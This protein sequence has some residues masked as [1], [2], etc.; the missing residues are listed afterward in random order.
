MSSQSDGRTFEVEEPDSNS[1]A[2]HVVS[3]VPEDGFSSSLVLLALFCQC[4]PEKTAAV[5]SDFLAVHDCSCMQLFIQGLEYAK[6]HL[7]EVK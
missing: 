7:R 3:T 4:P 1:S 6:Q 2:V 5:S